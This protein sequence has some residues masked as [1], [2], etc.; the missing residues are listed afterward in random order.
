M[1][2]KDMTAKFF[3]DLSGEEDAAD[4]S[5]LLGVCIAEIEG[6][7]KRGADLQRGGQRL[8]Y[9][10]AALGFYRYCL[11]NAA[12]GVASFK[13]GDVSIGMDGGVESSFKLYKEAVGAVK[14]YLEPDD[15]RFVCV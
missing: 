1:L 4:W 8:C 6:M 13:A 12:G 11:K 7:L 10:A 5:D 14:D 15:F 3:L 9:A 2:D